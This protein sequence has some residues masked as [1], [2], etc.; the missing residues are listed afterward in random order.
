INPRYLWFLV[1]SN[2]DLFHSTAVAYVELRI[3][4]STCE[5]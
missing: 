2:M 1:L 3:D 4:R 5:I